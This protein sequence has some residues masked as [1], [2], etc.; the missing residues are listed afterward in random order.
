MIIIATTRKQQQLKCSCCQQKFDREEI[1]KISNKN[2]CPKCLKE[3]E[4]KIKFNRSDFNILFDYICQIYGLDKPTGLMFKQ[5]KEYRGEGYEYTD[6][7]MYYTLKYYFDVLENQVLEGSGLGIIPYYYDKARQHYNKVYDLTDLSE[8][9][10]LTNKV[11]VINTIN[12][13]HKEEKKQPLPLV[14][15]WENI[16]DENS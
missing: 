8:A 6:I 9:Y 13:K 1:T 4:Q 11:K 3:H 7:G 12:K 5:M 2:Y 15:D 14:I 10:E 16:E